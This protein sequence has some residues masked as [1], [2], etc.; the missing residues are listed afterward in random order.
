M[1]L[2]PILLRINAIQHKHLSKRTQYTVE[3]NAK[4]LC[5]IFTL[6]VPTKIY[7]VQK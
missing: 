5:I 6:L 1:Q 4:P 2:I 3:M 7:M